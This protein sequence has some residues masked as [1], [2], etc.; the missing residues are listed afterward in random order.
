M[1]GPADDRSRER[2]AE[3]RQKWEADAEAEAAD[4]KSARAAGVSAPLPAAADPVAL[5]P[6]VVLFT[7]SLMA[8]LWFAQKVQTKRGKKGRI[9]Y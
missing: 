5:P 9:K 8:S 3:K 6:L 1:G 4:R 7:A 2:L